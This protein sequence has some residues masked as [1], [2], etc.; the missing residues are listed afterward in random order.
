MAYLNF[1]IGWL[2][3][4][5]KGDRATLM[6]LLIALVVDNH[7]LT[8]LL[9]NMVVDIVAIEASTQMDSTVQA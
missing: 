8:N 7:S 4:E 6:Y 3:S 9:A 2:S 1:S 5:S